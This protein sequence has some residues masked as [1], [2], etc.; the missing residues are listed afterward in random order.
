MPERAPPARGFTLLEVLVALAIVAVAL[1]ALVRLAA[2]GTQ[3]RSQMETRT[4]AHW[5]A[6][7]R[8]AALR[9]GAEWPAPGMTEGRAEQAGRLWTWRQEVSP[10]PDPDIREI[11]VRVSDEQARAVS[12]LTAYLAQPPGAKAVAN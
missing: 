7:N 10:T 4:L 6:V 2:S 5:V 1:V 12:L 11:R 8:V 3:I 9:A